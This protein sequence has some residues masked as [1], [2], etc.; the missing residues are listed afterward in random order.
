MKLTDLCGSFGSKNVPTRRSFSFLPPRPLLA[1]RPRLQRRPWRPGTAGTRIPG[2]SY[3]TRPAGNRN[4]ATDGQL[5][6]SVCGSDV[7]KV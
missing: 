5:P 1:R 3:L 2:R 6:E 4:E 7:S